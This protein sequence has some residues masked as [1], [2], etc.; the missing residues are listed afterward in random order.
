MA[1]EVPSIG[2]ILL[3]VCRCSR[4]SEKNQK[5]FSL[6][7]SLR[8]GNNRYADESTCLRNSTRGFSMGKK[9]PK[10]DPQPARIAPTGDGYMPLYCAAQWIATGGHAVAWD[11]VADAVWHQSYQALCDAIA[12]EEVNVIGEREGE[13]KPVPTY[14]FANC[15]ISHHASPCFPDNGQFYL[16]SCP[17]IDE[18]RWQEGLHDSMIGRGGIPNW[19]RLIVRRKDVRRLWPLRDAQASI[20]T[21]RTGMRGRPTSR[22][23]VQREHIARWERGEALRGVREEALALWNWLQSRHPE[24]APATPK[25]IEETIRAEHRARKAKPGK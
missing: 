17:Y 1:D 10:H 13:K 4:H 22:H 21:T 2:I 19:D 11:V 20:R 3:L 16:S 24:A 12:S 6:S 7:E 23:V 8:K 15:E 9:R 5:N 25:T 14:L 18:T